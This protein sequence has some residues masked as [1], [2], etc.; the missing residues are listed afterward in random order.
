M[1]ALAC[2]AAPG[3]ASRYA[4]G[5]SAAGGSSSGSVPDLEGREAAEGVDLFRA[6]DLRAIEGVAH[7]VDGLVVGRAIDRE[8][9]AVLAAVREGEA[10]RVA[11]A[12]ALAVD[13]LGG[14]RQ[15]A[16]RLRADALRAKQRLEVG[17][18]VFVRTQKHL[19]QI[20]RVD[21]RLGELVVSRHRE[22]GYLR[23]L[24][25]KLGGGRAYVGAFG[26]DQV[27][28]LGARVAAH[29]RV[30]LVDVALHVVG[31][32]VVA[33]RHRRLVAH[34]LLHH[35]PVAGGSED[36]RV[37][38]ELVAVLYRGVVDLRRDAARVHERRRIVPEALAGGGDL[39]R[40]LARGG[41]F[42]SRH[43]DAELALGAAQPFLQRAANRGR[44][45]ARVPVEA[46]HAAERLEPVGIGEAAEHFL[47][48]EFTGEEQHDLARERHHALEQPWRRMAAVERKLGDAGAGHAPIVGAR[49][50]LAV[51]DREERGRERRADE[52]GERRRRREQHRDDEGQQDEHGGE[53]PR[54]RQSLDGRAQ[55]RHRANP[56]QV[57]AWPPRPL[58]HGARLEP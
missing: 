20:A 30:R 23:L 9:R 1:A 5:T 14:E 3:S 54:H 10:R 29:R 44:Q 13:E 33:T 50:T 46:E 58:T 12:G 22:Q 52:Q 39:G 24:P 43:V 26:G 35:A 18:R 42:A 53:Y 19:V 25:G 16:Q 15:R 21:V 11:V 17:R 48:A 6:P 32:P 41:A 49:T 45:A 51:E 2:R 28:R 36:E 4:S 27:E 8:G 40:R 34:A 38:I 47:A 7:D 56:P 31:E 57:D 55:R 37:V